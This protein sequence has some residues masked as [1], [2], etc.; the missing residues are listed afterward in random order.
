MDESTFNPAKSR[1]T[2]PRGQPRSWLLGHYARSLPS[3]R[4]EKAQ[5][6]SFCRLRRQT[7]LWWD[8][9]WRSKDGKRGEKLSTETGEVQLVSAPAR[10]PGPHH[11]GSVG[12]A[13]R[14]SQARRTGPEC[15]EGPRS[16]S[17][18]RFRGRSTYGQRDA[19][20]LDSWA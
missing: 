12:S 14:R 9:R 18:S 17:R 20:P 1:D 6:R 4:G 13:S 3:E 7:A 16:T 2:N 11:R 8:V 5:P 15:L 19:V 10:V